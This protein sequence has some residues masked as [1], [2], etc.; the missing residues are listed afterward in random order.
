MYEPTAIAWLI[1][2]LPLAA[3]V[4]AALGVRHEVADARQPATHRGRRH[5]LDLRD[6]PRA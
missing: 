2:A 5:G 4:L 1:L 6:R 3:M